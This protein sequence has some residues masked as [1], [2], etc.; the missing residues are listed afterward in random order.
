MRAK[1][2]KKGSSSSSSSP[3]CYSRLR[4]LS[5]NASLSSLTSFSD[6]PAARPD[7][8]RLSQP[9]C[10]LPFHARPSHAVCYFFSAS[11][12]SVLHRASFR[13]VVRPPFVVNAD[14]GRFATVQPRC[15]LGE[16]MSIKEVFER[17]RVLFWTLSYLEIWAHD[18]MSS[19]V[20]RV[21]N[22]LSENASPHIYQWSCSHF[23]SHAVIKGNYHV[24][25]CGNQRGDGVHESHYVATGS[26]DFTTATEPSLP[27]MP[28][29]P[30]IGVETSTTQAPDNVN[31]NEDEERRNRRRKNK[32]SMKK[33]FKKFMKE[34]G[35]RFDALDQHV[36]RLEKN[37][38]AMK[39]YMRRMSKDKFVDKEIA[40]IRRMML[41]KV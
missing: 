34:V 19:L 12:A 3:P 29:V 26:I 23:P 1:R 28:P 7:A 2:T 16:R 41:M 22:W 39:K 38:K 14:S 40:S 20:G 21:A 9:R 10:L 15:L 4:R 11:Q 33:M 37:F 30:P 25:A 27:P 8:G 36:E 5:L 6:T 31:A 24:E 32:K 18:T 35:K 17:S 13:V